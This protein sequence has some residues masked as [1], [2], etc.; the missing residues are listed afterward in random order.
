MHCAFEIT[1]FWKNHNKKYRF[2]FFLCT[3]KVLEWIECTESKTRS[4][5]QVKNRVLKYECNH[6][7]KCWASH[8]TEFGQSTKVTLPRIIHLLYI[9][10]TVLFFFIW[11]GMRFSFFLWPTLKAA[12]WLWVFSFRPLD[13][14]YLGFV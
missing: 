14:L 1:D 13:I 12:F 7:E 10:N 8:N 6:L 11:K 9:G 2:R 4:T 5:C 3:Q